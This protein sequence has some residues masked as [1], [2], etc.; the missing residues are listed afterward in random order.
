MFLP[1]L[2]SCLT[3]EG[4]A[5]RISNLLTGS[6]SCWGLRVF[7]SPSFASSKGQ[8]M[9]RLAVVSVP[10]RRGYWDLERDKAC[11]IG[12]GLQ[13]WTLQDAG[14]LPLPPLTVAPGELKL[15]L[16]QGTL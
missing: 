5:G 15:R 13:L 8:V 12:L 2:L 3:A 9:A 11:Q 6:C 10:V 4:S 7:T 16:E 14:S 1:L